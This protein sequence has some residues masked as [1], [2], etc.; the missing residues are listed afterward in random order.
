MKNNITERLACIQKLQE[1]IMDIKTAQEQYIR[2]LMQDILEGHGE[3][4]PLS[5]DIKLVIHS[6]FAM[7]PILDEQINGAFLSEDGNAFLITEDEPDGK[8]FCEFY[9]NEEQAFVLEELVKRLNEPRQDTKDK[10][11]R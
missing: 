10:E 5:C 8:E 4:N 6:A 3:D 2:S 11:K 1:A 9:T 7:T